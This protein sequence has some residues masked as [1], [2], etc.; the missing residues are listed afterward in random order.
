M[1]EVRRISLNFLC[2]SD[3]N[4]Q[5]CFRDMDVT[6]KRFKNGFF[7]TGDL[8]V[9]YSNAAIYVVYPSKDIIIP[10]GKVKFCEY[11]IVGGS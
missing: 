7:N 6:R 4:Y 9:M 11:S 5:Q 1:K 2:I 10:G 8:A 3:R